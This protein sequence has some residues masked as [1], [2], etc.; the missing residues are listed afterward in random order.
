MGSQA[1]SS[2]DLKGK[3]KYSVTAKQQQTTTMSWNDYVG[4]VQKLGFTKC[5]II[6]RQNYQTL[7]STTAQDI[8]TAWKD[9]DVQINEN[10]ELL[11]NWEDVKKN[12]FCFYQTKFNI[13]LRDDEAGTYVVGLK[14]KMVVV[15]RQFK[16]IWFVA[17]GEAKKKG[18]KKDDNA[19][20]F[21][22][23]PDAF[24]KISKNVFDAL[25]DAG[26]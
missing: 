6:N 11:D 13:L 17:A 12:N 3:H 8:A 10:Q 1:S 9:G 2:P 14:G 24:N 15:A 26:L 5:T 7:A 18:G 23:A 20:G 22:G 21:G 16:S 25:E 19:K 4:A